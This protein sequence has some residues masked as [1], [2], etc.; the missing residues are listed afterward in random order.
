MKEDL[1]KW[2]IMTLLQ[3]RGVVSYDQWNYDMME[4]GLETQLTVFGESNTSIVLRFAVLYSDPFGRGI[5]ERI[6][7]D[8]YKIELRNYKLEQLIK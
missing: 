6:P 5:S 8:E 1:N 4:V 2:V 7:Y 3:K